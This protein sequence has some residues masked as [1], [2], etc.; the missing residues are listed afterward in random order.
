MFIWWVSV[1]LVYC[2]GFAQYQCGRVHWQ[3]VEPGIVCIQVLK[4]Q[5]LLL[6]SI[7]VTGCTDRIPNKE[8][9][10]G[11]G[12]YSEL[13]ATWWNLP[14]YGELSCTV[15][16]A[17]IEPSTKIMWTIFCVSCKYE[18]ANSGLFWACM[19][20]LNLYHTKMVFYLPPSSK[21]RVNKWPTFNEYNTYVSSS[22]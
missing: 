20:E 3:F 1:L 12:S 14:K 11:E 4:Q 2:C 6:R 8:L 15:I 5:R 17:F 22:S 10:G 19:N 13:A 7:L 21:Q 18:C 9:L 16:R